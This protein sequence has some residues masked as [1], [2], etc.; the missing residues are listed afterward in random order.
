MSQKKWAFGH[1]K[2]NGNFLFEEVGILDKEKKVK[3]K[4][5]Y[6]E[7]KRLYPNLSKRVMHYEPHSFA[8]I[9]L[10]LSDGVRMLYD[11]DNKRAV[12]VHNDG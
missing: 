2:K 4:D 8:T 6:E 3:W 12:I 1:S 9:Q 5:V 10:F 11:Y 7:F